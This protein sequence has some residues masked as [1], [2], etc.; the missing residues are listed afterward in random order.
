[1][2]RRTI[3][4]WLKRLDTDESFEQAVTDTH[5]SGRNRK[6]S[7]EEQ[8]QFEATVHESPEEDGLDAPA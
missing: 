6:L 2:Q 8:E 1:M 4:S 5:R 7:E 3:Y